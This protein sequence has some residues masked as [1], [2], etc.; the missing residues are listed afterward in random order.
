MAE[1][2][3]L[4]VVGLDGASYTFLKDL[5]EREELPF[6]KSLQERGSLQPLES[7]KIPLTAIAW[8]A[9]YTGKNPGKSNIPGF[10]RQQP[11]S[12]MWEYVSPAERSSQEMWKM[13]SDQGKRSILLGTIFCQNRGD[14]D[15]IF[16]GGE[17]CGDIQRCVYPEALKEEIFGRFAY[18]PYTTYGSVDEMKGF[19]ENKF[20]IAS[21]LNAAYQWDMFFLGFMEPDTTHAYYHCTDLEFVLESYRTIDRGL[22]ALVD[23]MGEDVDIV[24]YSDHGNRPYPKAF[25]VN[26]WL[27]NNGFLSIRNRRSIR[28]HHLAQYRKSLRNMPNSWSTARRLFSRFY[29]TGRLITKL[30][31]RLHKWVLK[32]APALPAMQADETTSKVGRGGHV[33]I[34][35]GELIDYSR[36]SAY[37]FL[38]HGGNFAGLCIN[39]QSTL[40][41]GTVSDADY[42]TYRNRLIETLEATVD[43]KTGERVIRNIW[44]REELFEGPYA[45]DFPDLVFECRDNYFTYVS[46]D[47]IDRHNL[48]FEFE[49]CQHEL[50][51]MLLCAGESFA[52][53]VCHRSQ[54]MDIA[55]TLLYAMGAKIPSDLDG[56]PIEMLFKPEYRLNNPVCFEDSDTELDPQMAEGY[57]TDEQLLIEQRLRDLGYIE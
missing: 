49:N 21:H 53:E 32:I 34:N 2:G 45:G 55:P 46:E 50:D 47:D 51:G 43:P 44:K 30:F 10:V 20:R 25:H 57:T 36:S 7:L 18:E 37:A 40:P 11:N 52:N 31:P 35:P 19:I 22:A 56:R 42:E 54:I 5:L 3:R 41:E 8:T 16:I 48:V 15:G 24:V 4:L 33:V 17:Y 29:Y 6:F 28:S 13:L 14:F 1:D 39:R 9:S 23:E 26:S 27:Y 12:Y 38:N